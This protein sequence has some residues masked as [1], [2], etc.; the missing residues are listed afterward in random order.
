MENILTQN[1]LNGNNVPQTLERTIFYNHLI[2]AFLTCPF[3][4]ILTCQHKNPDILD[5]MFI[6][7]IPNSLYTDYTQTI[8]LLELWSDHSPV[9]LTIEYRVWPSPPQ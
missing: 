1:I 3:L 5:N 6:A 9:S 4:A 2:P 7:K 8:H